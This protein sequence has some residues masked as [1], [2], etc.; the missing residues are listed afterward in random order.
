MVVPASFPCPC[1]TSSLAYCKRREA[2]RGPGNE[3]TVF[4]CSV[5]E[6]AEWLKLK[7]EWVLYIMTRFS[8]RDS[9][10]SHSVQ[11]WHLEHNGMRND[12]HASLLIWE[13]EKSGCN[14]ARLQG[15]FLTDMKSSC[16]KRP[17]TMHAVCRNARYPRLVY[18][19]EYRQ[20]E[21]AKALSWKCYDACINRTSL[22]VTVLT[23]LQSS[24]MMIKMYRHR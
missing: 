14:T 3:A 1:P 24:P 20:F 5:K 2:G 8:K 11:Y 19:T 13:G 4:H 23:Y 9:F 7:N 21:K 12:D 22:S 17:H 10:L 18:V 16:F 15:L 6:Y